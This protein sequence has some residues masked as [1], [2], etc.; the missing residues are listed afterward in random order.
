[1][2]KNEQ[3][4]FQWLIEKKGYTKEQIIFNK[5]KSPDFLCKD[6][7][8]FEVKS[9]MA[10]SKAKLF[11]FDLQ[12]DILKN[13]DIIIVFNKGK[14]IAEFEWGNK[15]NSKFVIVSHRLHDEKVAKLEKEMSE[16]DT[17]EAGL[18]FKKVINVF[19]IH[20]TAYFSIPS[21]WIKDFK[22]DIS[23][24]LLIKFNPKKPT[25]AKLIWKRKI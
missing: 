5:N 13:K 25:E 3:M 18:I 11:F 22:I 15:E 23:K 2:N 24:P 9:I 8:R 14:F 4:A 17:D 6:G 20:G 19:K 7:K 10:K 21:Y 12:L 1:M 16:G